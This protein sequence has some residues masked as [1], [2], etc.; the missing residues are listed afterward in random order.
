MSIQCE[1]Q[2]Y[3]VLMKALDLFMSVDPKS[4]ENLLKLFEEADQQAQ[5]NKSNKGQYQHQKSRVPNNKL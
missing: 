4:E 1:Y 3:P 5:I 2:R